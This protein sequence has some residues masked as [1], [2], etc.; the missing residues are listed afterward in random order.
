MFILLLIVVLL[1]PTIIQALVENIEP[2]MS[3]MTSL[4]ICTVT[5]FVIAKVNKDNK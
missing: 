3:L 5:A 2:A 4:I 1:L